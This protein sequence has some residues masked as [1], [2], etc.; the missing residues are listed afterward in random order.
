MEL[1]CGGHKGGWMR[2]VDLDTSRGDNCPTG[3]TKT[4]TPNTSG[5]PAT[6]V[7]RSTSSNAGCYST[8]FTVNGTSYYK[9]CGRVRGYQKGTTDGFYPALNSINGIYV[10]GVS[11]TIGSPRKHVWTYASGYSDGLIRLSGNCPCAAGHGDAPDFFV[12][13]NFYCE[14]GTTDVSYST[15]YT[16]D[17]LWDGNGCIQTNNNCC[18]DIGA[19]WFFRQFP[20]VQGDNIEVRL[21]TNELFIDEAV[22][23]DQVQLFV[24]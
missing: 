2:I 16:G 9:I 6:D 20:T 3:W 13:D 17:P 18:T 19:P 10:D 21:C 24:Q 7:C 22:V 4:T 23:V 14:S 12:K 8:H 15:Y 5:N 11:I 1:E